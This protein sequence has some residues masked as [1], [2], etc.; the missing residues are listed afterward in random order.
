[1]EGLALKYFVLNPNKQDGFGVA[2]REAIRTYAKCI[3]STDRQLSLDL[4][5]WMDEIEEQINEIQ[6]QINENPY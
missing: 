6:E 1:M 3:S 4:F 2:S 5:Q